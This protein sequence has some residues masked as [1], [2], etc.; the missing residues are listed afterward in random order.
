MS[1]LFSGFSINEWWVRSEFVSRPENQTSKAVLCRVGVSHEPSIS[2]CV[3]ISIVSNY[4]F[5]AYCFVSLFIKIPVIMNSESKKNQS[6]TDEKVISPTPTV[7]QLEEA[8]EERTQSDRRDSNST[9]DV[10]TERRVANRRNSAEV[11]S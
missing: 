7:S 5:T 8:L 2:E 6:D 1:L 4:T 10:E 11:E 9:A 3:E